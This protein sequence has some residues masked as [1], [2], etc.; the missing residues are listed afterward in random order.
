MDKGIDIEISTALVLS[1]YESCATAIGYCKDTFRVNIADELQEDLNK[2][3]VALRNISSSWIEDLTRLAR[4]T[5]NPWVQLY[6]YAAIGK[7]DLSKSQ[8]G[9]KFL[10][11]ADAGLVSAD[12][13]LA[14][15]TLLMEQRRN[16]WGQTPSEVA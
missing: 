6:I 8:N 12:A 10:S 11:E 9:L 3:E 16:K 5:D 7:V 13:F 15:N 2:L 1:R 4:G 14:L